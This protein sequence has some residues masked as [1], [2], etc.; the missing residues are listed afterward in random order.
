[1]KKILLYAIALLGAALFAAGCSQEEDLARDGQGA[2]KFSLGIAASSRAA[3]AV[4]PAVYPWNHC[5]IRIYKYTAAAA[6]GEERPRELIR[7]YSSVEEM[8]SSMWLLSGDY[9]IAVELGSKAEATFEEITYRGETDFSVTEGRSANVEVACRIVNT[10]VE[11]EFDQSVSDLFTTERWVNV[12]LSDTYNQAAVVAGEVLYLRYAGYTGSKR[13]YF[14]LPEGQGAFSWRFRGVGVKEGEELVVMKDG[15][16]HIELTPGLCYKLRFKYSPDLGGSLSFEIAVDYSVSEIENEIKFVPDPQITGAGFEI[17]NP[18]DFIGGVLTYRVS[19]ISDLAKVTLATADRRI[20]IPLTTTTLPSDGI[21]VERVSASDILLTLG[22]PFFAK[23]PGG[24]QTLT[25]LAEDED[26]GEGEAS[27]V[28]R[29]QGVCSMLLDWNF[30]A[31]AYVLDPTATDVKIRYRETGASEWQETTLTA[32]EGGEKGLCKASLGV[33]SPAA[34]YECQLVFG[35]TAVG[36]SMTRTMPAVPT[37]P[38]AGFES[39]TD[40]TPLLPYASEALQFWDSGNHGSATLEKNV[41]TY[42]SNPRPESTGAL[43]AKLQSQYVALFGIG[44]FAA[45]NLF[46]GKYLA[47]NGTNGVLAFGKPFDFPYRPR[48]LRFWYKGTVGTID[49]TGSGSPVASGQ[50]DVAQVYALLCSTEGPHIVKTADTGTFLD[51]QSKTISYCSHVD[52]GSSVNDRTDGKIVASAIWENTTS[53][54]GWTEVTVDLVYNEEYADV[55]PTYLLLTTS[56][57][58][59]GDYFSGSTSSVMYLDDVEFVY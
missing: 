53:H 31:S 44:K 3:A 14:I 38:N 1:M 2:V 39:W 36:L 59:W 23:F 13:G 54:D 55:K 6:E 25:I 20:D 41:T 50:Q 10:I 4:D 17:K 35:S 43:C 19:A 22:S 33:L 46:V 16:K 15:T 29:T 40:G 56:A 21:S 7:R 37:I 18:Q 47:T 8:P 48:Q 34:G 24:D 45:G 32:V 5:A 49:R 26:G 30:E 28:V 57:S 27:S 42:E 11:V 52:G 58:K 12:A 51:L 9:V